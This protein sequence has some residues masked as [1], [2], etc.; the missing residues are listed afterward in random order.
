MIFVIIPAGG[1]GSRYSK[2]KS[3]L[4]EKITNKTVIEHTLSAF[5]NHQEIQGIVIACPE[6]EKP[7]YDKLKAKVTTPLI[8]TTGGN[9]RAESVYL[10]FSQIPQASY[11]L[12]HDA[13]RPNI[14]QQLI[15]DVIKGL[16]NSPVIIPGINVTD[17]IKRVKNNTVVETI[18]RNELKA[19]QTPQGFHYEALASAY[20]KISDRSKFTDE[21]SLMEALNID[22]KIVDGYWENLKITHPIDLTVCKALMTI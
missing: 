11:V 13:A 20:K 9:T 2:N 6:S 12:I 21:A 19:V 22:I 8:V 14:S 15:T 17:T 7:M 4:T 18:D 16:A 5:D 3:K 10:G 1:S